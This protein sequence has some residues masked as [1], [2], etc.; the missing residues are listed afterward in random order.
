M[1]SSSSRMH[2]ISTP[3]HNFIGL[4]KSIPARFQTAQRLLNL[5]FLFVF[6]PLPRFFSLSLRHCPI[7]FELCCSFLPM[8]FRR[9]TLFKLGELS[10]IPIAQCIFQII[11]CQRCTRSCQ[12]LHSGIFNNCT[13]REQLFRKFQ[14]QYVEFFCIENV[15]TSSVFSVFW[16][17]NHGRNWKCRWQGMCEL[18]G[19][20]ANSQISLAYLWNFYPLYII[21]QNSRSHKGINRIFGA[22]K[23]LYDSLRSSYTVPNIVVSFFSRC[24][25]AIYKKMTE[26]FLQ[27]SKTFNIK[28]LQ[29]MLSVFSKTCTSN[30]IVPK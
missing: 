26:L 16:R 2:L 22:D 14:K 21:R 5:I 13:T 3:P 9:R 11:A 27:R 28:G 4:F 18:G 17:I 10:I 15:L 6:C 29:H 23:L 24:Y 20:G 1:F 7:Y 25:C 19:Y 30:A 12:R 8:Y